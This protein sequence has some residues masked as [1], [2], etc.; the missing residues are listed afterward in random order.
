MVGKAIS[1]LWSFIF[2]MSSRAFDC[3]V[4][5][6]RSMGGFLWRGGMGQ[7]WRIREGWCCSILCYCDL[8]F[9][10][11]KYLNLACLFTSYL[12]NLHCDVIIQVLYFRLSEC[13]LPC[14]YQ[15]HVISIGRFKLRLPQ[16]VFFS[17]WDIRLGIYASVVKQYCRN[18]P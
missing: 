3:L 14:I 5:K 8:K 9:R 16:P 2:R 12:R 13:I 11:K 15:S 10:R 17:L 6:H 1:D 7:G 4:R 18:P